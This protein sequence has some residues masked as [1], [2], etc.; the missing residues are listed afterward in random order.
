MTLR[1]LI[2]AVGE[3][4]LILVALFA[5]APVAA[6]VVGRLHV[7]GRGAMKPW[8]Y[9]YSALVYLACVPGMLAAVL[10][11][12]T[13]FFTRESLLDVDA[14]V[15]FLPIISMVV[16]LVVISGSVHFEQVP[17]F[18]RLSG[19]MI[20]LAISFGIGLA[21]SKTRIWLFFGAPMWT[22]LVVALVVFVGLRS[23][24]RMAARGRGRQGQ[25]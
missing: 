1:E 7:R 12:Y 22:L 16:T 6:W 24:T 2:G 4:P 11:A 25:S 14:L 21:I 13:L 19:L 5:L 8:K 17:G 10:T 23:S 20:T 9:L 18:D 15:F 3:H